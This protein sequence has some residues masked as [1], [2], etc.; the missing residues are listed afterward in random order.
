MQNLD[1]YF[2]YYEKYI[3]KHIKNSNSNIDKDITAYRRKLKGYFFNCNLKKI[4]PKMP[5][6][7]ENFVDS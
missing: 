7:N 1:R 4:L 6:I 3:P 2:D 5:K